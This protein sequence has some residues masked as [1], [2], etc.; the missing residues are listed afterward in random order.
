M[1]KS[2][3]TL[4]FAIIAMF[5][6]SGYVSCSDDDDN[7]SESINSGTLTFTFAVSDDALNKL[8]YNVTT[9]SDSGK[10]RDLV[11]D[12]ENCNAAIPAYIMAQ[13]PTCTN[14]YTVSYSISSFPASY[15]FRLTTAMRDGVTVDNDTQ[16][17]IGA[18]MFYNFTSNNG[19]M[20]YNV[21]G[22]NS[23]VTG[24]NLD[25][26]VT[27]LSSSSES[28]VGVITIDDKGNVTV[29]TGSTAFAG[30]FSDN[31]LIPIDDLIR[32]GDLDST[33]TSR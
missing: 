20:K 25:S 5:L 1:K 17:S 3:R 29:E 14:A 2:L 4:V 15:A 9:I 8:A 21:Q 22:Y 16:Y 23:T 10:Y 31:S 32:N 33:R 6:V 27:S 18:S 28:Y 19:S 7:V 24:Q 30:F 13:Y 12:S 26:Y 11:L